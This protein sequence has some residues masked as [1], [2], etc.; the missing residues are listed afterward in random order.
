RQLV[1][2]GQKLL[3]GHWVFPEATKHATRHQVRIVLV[4]AARRHAMMRRLDDHTD[5]VRLEDVVDGIG[6]L[7][8]HLLLDLQSL[9][10]GFNDTRKL[11][12]ADDPARRHIG[13]PCAADD[14]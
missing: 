9:R 12:D 7:R 1:R 14:W 2:Q 10:I 4:Y 13:D 3:T 11:G 5:A 8:R 6:Y